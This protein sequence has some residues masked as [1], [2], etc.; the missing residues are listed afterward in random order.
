M[1]LFQT[2]MALPIA[3]CAAMLFV[4]VTVSWRLPQKLGGR[5]Y[6]VLLM[7]AICWMLSNI[8]EKVAE[9]ISGKL[10]FANCQYVFTTTCSL[11]WYVFACI[12]CRRYSWVTPNIVRAL[13]LGPVLIALFAIIDPWV[14]GLRTS[15]E[16]RIND[17]GWLGS[18][19]VLHVEYGPLFLF[20]LVYGYSLILIGLALLS[21]F[22]IESPPAYRR[23][24]ILLTATGFFPA[25][26][27]FLYVMGCRPFGDVDLSP[28]GL[29]IGSMIGAWILLHHWAFDIVPLASNLV[30]QALLDPV[31]VLD[32]EER[33]VDRNR[34]AE[35]LESAAPFEVGIPLRAAFPAIV[36]YL[37]EVSH[38]P[39]IGEMEGSSQ[40]PLKLSWGGRQRRFEIR[41][42]QIH[43]AT[44]YLGRML[45]LIDI[46]D[47]VEFEENRDRLVQAMHRS[48]M[49]E[50]LGYLAG[51]VSHDFNNLLVGIMG[52]AALIRDE[53]EPNSRT[54]RLADHIL[55]AGENAADL[56]QQLQTYSGQPVST[57]R[58]IAT[59]NL[60]EET[61]DFLRW[62]MHRNITL[63]LECE[64][65]IPWIQGDTGQLSQMLT[66]LVSN[67]SDA[68]GTRDGRISLIAKVVSLET[69]DEIRH[70]L[71][72]RELRPGLFV[73]IEVRDSGCGM[74]KETLSRIFEP[75]FSTKSDGRGLGLAAVLGVMRA[76]RGGI[77]AESSPDAGTTFR[78]FFPA[79]SPPISPTD[80]SIVV[81]ICPRSDIVADISSVDCD[82][83]PTSVE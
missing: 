80:G 64:R 40:P 34:S 28:F 30:F 76:H 20:V 16:M 69:K 10:F 6:Q 19:P 23:R 49:L 25:L 81:D 38:L 82:S 7:A 77:D 51:T 50:S 79:S 70:L 29:A 9:S 42:S 2:T 58:P 27:N 41:V 22:V 72:S 43:E 39:A 75:F 78:L 53:A 60:L 47:R 57:L 66:H 5:A 12:Y 59:E 56:T 83:P 63:D 37:R 36:S 46:T 44:H 67:A 45:Q 3:L 33:I 32:E 17:L 35:R 4:V 71:Y 18:F 61:V 26:F 74:N 8:G 55:R 52:N 62:T 54:R 21:I 11:C 65:D 14:H 15:V 73:V 24:I 31:L 1:S 13:S 68:I 48:Q